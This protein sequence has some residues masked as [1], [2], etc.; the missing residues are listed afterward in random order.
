MRNYL[1]NAKGFT[2]IELVIVIAILG[3]LATIAIPKVQ[4]ILDSSQDKVNTVNE[5]VVQNAIDMYYAEYQEYPDAND[6]ESLEEKLKDFIN[7]IPDY[8]KDNYTYDKTTGE[9]KP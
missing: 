3:M 2:L 5:M 6:M 9:I 7:E 4:E 8:I 1:G